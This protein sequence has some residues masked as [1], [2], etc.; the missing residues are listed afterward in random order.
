MP[1]N[2]KEIEELKDKI[3]HLKHEKQLELVKEGKAYHCIDCNE[4]VEYGAISYKEREQGQLC[5]SCYSKKKLEE[6]KQKFLFKFKNSKLVDVVPYNNCY[7]DWDE[8]DAIIIEKNGKKYKIKIGGYED[9]Y[10]VMEDV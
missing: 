10:L 8:V 1:D 5:F 7:W 6:N 2:E 9:L 4:I 3:K